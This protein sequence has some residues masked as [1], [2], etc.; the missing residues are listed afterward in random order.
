MVLLE[1]VKWTDNVLNEEIV[2]R[3]R[4]KTIENSTKRRDRLV[5]HIL[6][7]TELVKQ[8]GLRQT[9]NGGNRGG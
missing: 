8:V 1:I 7:Q 3:L 5:V 2:K 6:R 4:A 9:G